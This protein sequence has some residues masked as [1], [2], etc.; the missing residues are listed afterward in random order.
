MAEFDNYKRRTIKNN[1]QIVKSANE[2]LIDEIIEIR[3]N[4]ER[5]F[6]SN[7]HGNKFVEGM[8]LTYA[9]LNDILQ[10]HGL[11]SY[12][13][14]GQKFNPELHHAIMSAYHES[15]PES[16]ISHVQE[17]GY[18]LHG[19]IIKHAKVVVSSGKREE[20]KHN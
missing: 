16:H 5:A 3:E 9:K 15:I 13:E 6:K 8:K 7:D 4:F 14:L 17:H 2:G 12:A 1:E 20:K 18:K 11:E 19:K 10:K